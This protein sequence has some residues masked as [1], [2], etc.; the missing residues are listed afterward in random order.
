M[1]TKLTGVLAGIVMVVGLAGF[2]AALVSKAFSQGNVKV[3]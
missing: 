3:A 1:R 2:A